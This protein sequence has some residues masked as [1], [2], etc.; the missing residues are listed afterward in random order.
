MY[1]DAF[2]KALKERR[3]A[4]LKVMGYIAVVMITF[5]GLFILYRHWRYPYGFIGCL[6]PCF[7]QTFISYA[8]DHDG[9]Y[10]KGELTPLESLQLL[11]KGG[12]AYWGYFAGITGSEKETKKRLESGGKLDETVSSWVYWPGFRS[13]DSQ[14]LDE[15]L[16]SHKY[17]LAVLWEKTAGISIFGDRTRDK[18]L[19]AICSN[20]RWAQI[21]GN[22]WDGFLKE[23][24]RYRRVIFDYRNQ[25]TQIGRASCR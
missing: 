20:S 25:Q 13:D 16:P 2:T 17:E 23:Q 8:S 7:C 15:L 21:P 12:Y 22:E 19:H 10:P 1:G 18:G 6:V 4:W 11:Y 5:G 14:L 3:K 24:E 9:W